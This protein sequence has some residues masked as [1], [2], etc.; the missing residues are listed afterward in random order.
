MHIS[1][2][3]ILVI[4]Q[5]LACIGHALIRQLGRFSGVALWRKDGF[6]SSLRK[7]LFMLYFIHLE[8]SRHPANSLAHM[9][10]GEKIH[11]ELKC[12]HDADPAASVKIHW[13]RDCR[14]T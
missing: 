14:I 12:C 3:P 5:K 11:R 8:A 1:Q 6:T 13:N 10:L 9:N 7:V 4:F 2:D